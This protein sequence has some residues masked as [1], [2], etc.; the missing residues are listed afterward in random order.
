MPEEL[1]LVNDLH[2]TFSNDGGF[3]HVTLRDA[4]D[5]DVFHLGEDELL[6]L[7]G[8]LNQLFDNKQLPA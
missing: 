2:A 8:Y 3:A 1:H 7:R 6:S 4:D 5:H